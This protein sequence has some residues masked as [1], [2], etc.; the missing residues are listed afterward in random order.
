MSSS[1][2][3]SSGARICASCAGAANTWTTSR[4]RGCCTPRS[5]AARLRTGAS[6]RSIRPAARARPGVHAVITAADIGAPVPKIPLRQEA[7]PEFTRFE[8][9]VI[10]RAQGPL[11]RRADRG[12]GRGHAGAG[13]GCARGDRGRYREPA[14]H[15]RSR[16]GAPRRG[17]VVRGGRHQ[18]RQ[19]ASRPSK[20]TP[21]PPS[22]PRPI[23]GASTSRCS[24][25]PRC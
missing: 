24:A 13:R 6:A 11:C 21:T 8:Q 4:G 12:G 2:A 14:R 22:R 5:C 18:S 10:A 19:H 25:S 15:R 17:A 16:R 3:R 7:M 9:P 1:A 20:A 23:R